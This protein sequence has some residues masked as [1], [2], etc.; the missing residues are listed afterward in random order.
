MDEI[1][2]KNILKTELIAICKCLACTV[3]PVQN[4]NSVC[5][6]GRGEI[7][8]RGPRPPIVAY[9][10]CVWDSAGQVGSIKSHLA[11]GGPT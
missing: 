2:I 1:N 3:E 8:C 6:S 11:Q 4:G 9:S 7:I 10:A 5:R